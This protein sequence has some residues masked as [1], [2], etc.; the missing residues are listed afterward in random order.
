MCFKIKILAEVLSIP[1]SALTQIVFKFIRLIFACER[2]I[3]YLLMRSQ[4]CSI[5]FFDV[6][7]AEETAFFNIIL[8]KAFVTLSRCLWTVNIV[9]AQIFN[10][11]IFPLLINKPCLL[12]I[13]IN[14]KIIKIAIIHC[15]QWLPLILL[16]FVKNS[17]LFLY[18]FT[19]F[20]FFLFL[21]PNFAPLFAQI[22][23]YFKFER[24]IKRKKYKI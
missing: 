3:I 17:K 20:D 13:L 6:T 1:L 2:F 9:F 22:L 10:S 23:A 8:S 4:L 19:K 15:Q 24:S 7:N 5:K 11:I 14:K 12:K 21:F 16:I 18:F